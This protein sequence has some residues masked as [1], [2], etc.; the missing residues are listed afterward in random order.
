MDGTFKVIKAPF[1]QLYSVHA[2]VK[3]NGDVKQ[4]PLVFVLMSGK[5]K[6][7]YRR[8][9]KAVQNLLPDHI[10]LQC[11]VADFK[12]TTMEGC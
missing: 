7:A 2:F 8:V 6:R 10:E 1:T 3:Q 5:R 12:S 9:L 4:V 11:V